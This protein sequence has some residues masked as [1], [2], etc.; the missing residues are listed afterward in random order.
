MKL[1]KLLNNASLYTTP[2]G[3]NIDVSQDMGPTINRTIESLERMM[4]YLPDA[5]N[6]LS[7]L[8]ELKLMVREKLPQSSS[9]IE[10]NGDEDFAGPSVL[11]MYDPKKPLASQEARILG[12]A[13][14]RE[15]G[16]LPPKI[17]RELTY[18]KDKIQEISGLEQQGSDPTDILQAY[19]SLAGR[20][21]MLLQ[22]VNSV[23]TLK[24]A[25]QEVT[26]RKQLKKIYPPGT[27]ITEQHVEHHAHG[28]VGDLEDALRIM[29]DSDSSLSYDAINRAM[30]DICDKDGCSPQDL[31]KLFRASHGDMTPDAWAKSLK[32][33]SVGEGIDQMIKDEAVMEMYETMRVGLGDRAWVAITKRLRSQGHDANLVESMINRAIIIANRS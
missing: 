23:N 26:E 19:E 30:R 28:S 15:I 27:D 7:K 16:G 18:V 8:A 13:G 31:H 29:V 11:Y 5:I 6:L 20:T 25:I 17:S 14:R 9:M 22:M 3:M 10:A 4:A 32:D 1:E 24:V 12:G 33:G 2:L 21:G